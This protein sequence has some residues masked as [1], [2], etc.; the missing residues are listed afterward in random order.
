MFDVLDLAPHTPVIAWSGGAMA[1]AERVV[2]FHD[3]PPQGPGDP[4]IYARGLGL[5]AGVVPLPHAGDRLRLDDPARVALFARRFA[6][7]VCVTLDGGDR[8][9][10][11]GGAA[12]WDRSPVRV[13]G[14]DGAVRERAA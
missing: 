11:D 6:P 2:L 5:V 13:L 14:S 8:L 12:R 7:D 3:S 9:D 4:A 1:V 10:F